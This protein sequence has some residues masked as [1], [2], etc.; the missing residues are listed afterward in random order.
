M[1][2]QA[3]LKTNFTAL[4][5]RIQKM[6]LL[7]EQLKNHNQALLAENR[8]ILLELEDQRTKSARLEEGYKNLKEVEKTSTKQNIT[9]IKR[10]INDIIGEI[11]KNISL[12]DVHK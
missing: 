12:M 11:D 3:E 2:E 7:H 8:R 6:I 9:Q 4:E 5:N 1:Q 10:R